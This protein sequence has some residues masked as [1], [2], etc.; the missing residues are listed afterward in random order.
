MSLDWNRNAC[1]ELPAKL[2]KSLCSILDYLV[3]GTMVY[4]TGSIK[5]EAT[6]DEF[7]RR[8][9]YAKALGFSLAKKGLPKSIRSTLLKFIGLHTNADRKTWLQFTQNLAKAWLI[10]EKAGR[11]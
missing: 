5:D 6:V 10:E 4:G 9:K 8:D 1:K 3:Y 11:R 2:P 7:M